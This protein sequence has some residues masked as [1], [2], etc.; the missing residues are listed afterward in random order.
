MGVNIG[1]TAGTAR[2]ARLSRQKLVG[3]YVASADLMKDGNITSSGYEYLLKT[4]RDQVWQF[5]NPFRTRCPPVATHT[6]PIS[7][8]RRKLK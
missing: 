4:Y 8:L 6:S 5:V 1:V 2:G 7:F 3:Q